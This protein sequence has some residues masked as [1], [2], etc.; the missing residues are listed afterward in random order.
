MRDH[1]IDRL[2]TSGT[3]CHRQR[4]WLFG[5]N[6]HAHHFVLSVPPTAR[7]PLRVSRPAFRRNVSEG[8]AFRRNDELGQHSA[9][10]RIRNQVACIPPAFHESS[11][12]ITGRPSALASVTMMKKGSG[13]PISK[14]ADPAASD[15]HTAPPANFHFGVRRLDSA[16]I[17]FFAAGG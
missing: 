12:L 13:V 5:D 7:E 16:F 14:L 3:L 10:S 9:Q 8:T 6:V 17:F 11:G 2:R 15:H 1:S 4:S